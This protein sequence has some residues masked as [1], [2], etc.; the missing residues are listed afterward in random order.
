MSTDEQQDQKTEVVEQIG[1]DF[2][3]TVV[4]S[5]HAKWTSHVEFFVVEIVGRSIPENKAL[6]TRKGSDDHVE[7][8]HAAERYFAGSVKWDGCS[9]VYFGDDNGYLHLCGR[10][11]FD[12]IASVLLQVYGRCGALMRARG[13]DLLDGEFT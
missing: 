8:V 9:H 7:D 2:G 4:Y 12:R 5:L 13:V 3:V 6:Y 1:G 10:E 11:H